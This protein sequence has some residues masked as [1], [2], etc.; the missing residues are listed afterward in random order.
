MFASRED[1]ETW[2]NDLK[3]DETSDLILGSFGITTNFAMSIE[4]SESEVSKSTASGS[5][6]N[7]ITFTWNVKDLRDSS[8][9]SEDANCYLTFSNGSVTKTIS[10]RVSG[11]KHTI[12]QNVDEYLL[13]GENRIT[14]MVT[15]LSSKVS[16]SR[17]ITYNVIALGLTSDYDI[18][19][20]WTGS[21][22][23]TIPYTLTGSDL[24]TTEW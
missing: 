7:T 8:T 23:L 16:G 3:G 4:I 9:T 19:Q 5:T 14:I 2:H 18:S 6:G 22:I 20:V 17:Q 12:T 1:W 11:S 13:D 15:G 21:D 10:F 24:T